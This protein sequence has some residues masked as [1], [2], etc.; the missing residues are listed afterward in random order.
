MLA[1]EI[2][3][4]GVAAGADGIAVSRRSMRLGSKIV[5]SKELNN[6]LVSIGAT[7][8]G[9]PLATTC[10]SSPAMYRVLLCSTPLCQYEAPQNVGQHEE[11]PHSTPDA[12]LQSVSMK[13]ARKLPA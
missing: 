10:L 1:Y 11:K 2:L 13:C 7:V 5:L 4:A 12:D 3:S 9:S 8:G 6:M